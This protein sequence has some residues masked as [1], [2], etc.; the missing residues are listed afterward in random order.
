MFFVE[1]KK[2]SENIKKANKRY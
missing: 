1:A 2:P